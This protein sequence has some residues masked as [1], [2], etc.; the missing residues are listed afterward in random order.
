MI[1]KLKKW[2]KYIIDPYKDF[3]YFEKE[4]AY[5]KGWR[6]QKPEENDGQRKEGAEESRKGS[7]ERFQR[8]V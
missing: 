6:K 2:K 8:L 3:N 5:G 1:V 7:G 4:N